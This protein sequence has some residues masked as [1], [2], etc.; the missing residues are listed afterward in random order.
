[1]L[2]VVQAFREGTHFS[3]FQIEL[4][5]SVRITQAHGSYSHHRCVRWPPMVPPLAPATEQMNVSHPIEDCF[6]FWRRSSNYFRVVYGDPYRRG[7]KENSSFVRQRNCWNES[8]RET[9]MT[10]VWITRKI[11]DPLA[12]SP[13]VCL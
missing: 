12:L 10:I 5:L 6:R 7:D 11:F 9:A 13:L 8:Q 3:L 2:M 4:Q 1:M